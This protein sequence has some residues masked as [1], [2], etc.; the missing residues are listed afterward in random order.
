MEDN[1]MSLSDDELSSLTHGDQWKRNVDKQFQALNLRQSNTDVEMA[2]IK[3]DV[4]ENTALTRQI[5]DDTKAMRDAWADGVA[6]KRFFC[7]LADAWTFLLRKVFLPGL[8][9]VLV[10][11][12]VKAILWGAKIPEWASAIFKLMG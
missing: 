8:V 10:L 12:I 11:V 6:M 3:N 9:T 1:A 4:A 2:N 7:R 5:A